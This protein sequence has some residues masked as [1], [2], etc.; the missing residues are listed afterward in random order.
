MADAESPLTSDASELSAVE[1][2]L[3]SALS[4]TSREIAHAE[5][6]DAEQRAEVYEI[7]QALQTDTEMHRAILKVLLRRP[8]G[9]ATD[10]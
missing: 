5:C 3:A 4:A 7:L 9:E 6:F 8:G 2:E 1:E 10:A